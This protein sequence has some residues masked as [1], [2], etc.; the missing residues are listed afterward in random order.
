MTLLCA[1]LFFMLGMSHSAC[2]FVFFT[3]GARFP[4][5]L[6]THVYEDV[7]QHHGNILIFTMHNFGCGD[8]ETEMVKKYGASFINYNLK[9]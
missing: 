5:P 4:D 6:F 8:V 9:S 1:K 3:C 2:R 7:D